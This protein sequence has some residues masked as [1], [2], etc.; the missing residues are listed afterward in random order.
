MSVATER[1]GCRTLLSEDLN[2]DQRFHGI[3]VVNPFATVTDDARSVQTG[4]DNEPRSNRNTSPE[5]Y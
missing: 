5:S 2:P 4:Q 1:S 3:V